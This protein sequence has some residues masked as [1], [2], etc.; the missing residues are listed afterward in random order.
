LQDTRYLLSRFPAGELLVSLETFLKRNGTITLRDRFVSVGL[1]E[2]TLRKKYRI[3]VL[4]ETPRGLRCK[5]IRYAR[6]F[7]APW[8]GPHP[9]L[10]VTL[11]RDSDDTTVRYEFRW[12]E[13]YVFLAGAALFGIGASS[14][15]ADI[16]FFQRAAE[17]LLAFGLG[18]AF[19]GLLVFLD[20]TYLSWRVRRA[21]IQM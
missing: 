15:K 5:I 21:L 16:S 9:T 11:E 2:E 13:Y 20:G 17:G 19:F 14:L 7:G 12:P 10:A 8:I 3:P 6:L 4:E 1:I 18:L